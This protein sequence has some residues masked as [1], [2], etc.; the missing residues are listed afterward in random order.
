MSTSTVY[1]CQYPFCLPLEVGQNGFVNTVTKVFNRA[2]IALQN[3]WLFIIG[4]LALWF[5]VNADQ[6]QFLSNE[7]THVNENN[8]THDFFFCSGKTCL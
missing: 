1:T 7:Q 3:D 2:G 5:C 4:Q 6:I 8:S